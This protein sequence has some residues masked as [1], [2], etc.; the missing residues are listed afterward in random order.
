[1]R[2]FNAWLETLAY[3]SGVFA[4]EA[5]VRSWSIQFLRL[6]RPDFYR[7]GLPTRTLA[8][9]FAGTIPKKFVR[10]HKN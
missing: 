7:C 1:M 8:A 9:H 4:S 3:A 6:D 10:M 2:V 5:L